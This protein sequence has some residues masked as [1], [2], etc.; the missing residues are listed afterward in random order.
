LVHSFAFK[1][2]LP[3]WVNEG[4]AMLYTELIHNTSEIRED[5]ILYLKKHCYDII[6]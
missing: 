1:K 4:I 6:G 3:F 2:K 5:T